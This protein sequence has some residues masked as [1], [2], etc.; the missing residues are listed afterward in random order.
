MTPRLGGAG[1]CA[2]CAAAVS[3]IASVDDVACV[4]LR[5][6]DSVDGATLR[7]MIERMRAATPTRDIALLIEDRADPARAAGADGVHLSDAAAYPDARRLLGPDAIV[8][9][10]C[11]GRDEAMTLADAG[12]DYIAF[13]AFD[14]P[15]PTPETLDLVAWWS[16][17]ITVPCVA[18]P[19]ATTDDR[20]ALAEAGAD[21]VAWVVPT[22]EATPE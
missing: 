16:A 9:A 22:S 1:D 8:G 6:R 14:D 10:T 13:G 12:A 3:R 18:A 2:L 19:G 4:L 5:T 17:T 15:A 7:N 11:A 20:R 21:F